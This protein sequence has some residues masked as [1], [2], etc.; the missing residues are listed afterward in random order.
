MK[1]RLSGSEGLL[2]PKT[3]PKWRLLANFGQLFGGVVP[4][5]FLMCFSVSRFSPF[6]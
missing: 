6:W 3:S 4:Y 5:V 2:D 1:M